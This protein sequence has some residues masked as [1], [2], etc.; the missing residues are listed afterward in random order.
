MHQK[1]SQTALQHNKHVGSCSP[2]PPPPLCTRS[3]RASSS[4][5]PL[6]ACCTWWDAMLL[7]RTV[8]T[9]RRPSQNAQYYCA[10]YDT[11]FVLLSHLNS[12][13]KHSDMWPEPSKTCHFCRHDL[14]HV[15][16]SAGGGHFW[17]M[18]K[19]SVS[20]APASFMSKF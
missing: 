16:S 8:T 13:E 2:P 20:R 5:K 19:I 15:E 3:P 4:A 7:L 9:T 6:K 18:L 17:R 10:H 1:T 14:T 11:L 12:N